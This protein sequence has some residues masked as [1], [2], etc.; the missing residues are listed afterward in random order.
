M[1]EHV[2]KHPMECDTDTYWKCVFDEEYNTRLYMDQLHFRECTLL[3]QKDEGD[4]IRRR[5]RLNPAPA[6]LPGPLQK[7]L[8]D[9][10]WV[11]EGTFDKKTKRY[12][13]VITPASKPERTHI[14]G[15]VWCEPIGDLGDKKVN[16]CARLKVEVKIM[17][18][19]GLVENRV[20]DDTR[21]S[22]ETA[23]RFTTEFVREKGW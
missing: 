21:K 10:S 15:E 8:G 4:R 20:F 2:M 18:V 7:V 1:P 13:F 11:E 14:S 5:V 3:E 6:D 17:L 9:L 12:A 19:G 22:Y 16:R 23:A